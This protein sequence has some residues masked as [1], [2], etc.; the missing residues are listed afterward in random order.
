MGCRFSQEDDYKPKYRRQYKGIEYIMKKNKNSWKLFKV[1]HMIHVQNG[2]MYHSDVYNN[3]LMAVG[4]S[5]VFFNINQIG[6]IK[7]KDPDWVYRSWKDV[8]RYGYIYESST[9]KLEIVK[10]VKHENMI[11]YTPE[12]IFIKFKRQFHPVQKWFTYYFNRAWRMIRMNN[13]KKLNNIMLYQKDLLSKSMINT[14]KE[15]EKLKEESMLSA[16][17][18]PN[19]NKNTNINIDK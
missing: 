15:I 11:T 18:L 9:I 3:V 19:I 5:G 7:P 8:T 6:I 12:F 10:K 17:S 13:T 16:T 4:I 1:S 14:K 2:N